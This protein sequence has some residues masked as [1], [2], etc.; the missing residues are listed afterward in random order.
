MV[1]TGFLKVIGPGFVSVMS[2]R[3]SSCTPIWV[4]LFRRSCV[5]SRTCTLVTDDKW[6]RYSLMFCRSPKDYSFA[7]N[8][9]TSK[10]KGKN[11]ALWRFKSYPLNSCVTGLR[12]LSPSEDV[13]V[14]PRLVIVTRRLKWS[15]YPEPDRIRIKIWCASGLSKPSG[16]QRRN[17]GLLC[18]S[19][20]AA[21]PCSLKQSRVPQGH[22][23]SSR[24][25]SQ[26]SF[27]MHAC[28]GIYVNCHSGGFACPFDWKCQRGF[29]APKQ[30]GRI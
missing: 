10:N 4:V 1:V 23:L 9:C 25:Q 29:V 18:S 13:S 26:L 2:M 28:R 16:P 5:V 27:C 15:A 24:H 12:N 7:R 6:P 11:K 30:H 17:K 3:N 8:N 22:V 14:R 21:I 20:V 19:E